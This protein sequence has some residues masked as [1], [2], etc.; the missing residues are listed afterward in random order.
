[1]ITNRPYT[2]VFIKERGWTLYKL[3]SRANSVNLANYHST[4]LGT[5]IYSTHVRTVRATGA[6]RPASGPDRSAAQFD[7]QQLA[8]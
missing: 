4:K 3:T 6:D 7:A 2:Y 5:L 8:D 1:M